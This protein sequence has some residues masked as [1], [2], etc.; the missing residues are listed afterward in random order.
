MRPHIHAGVVTGLATFGM[1][2]IAGTLWRTLAYR[3]KDKNPDSALAE[4]M[5]FVY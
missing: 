3:M 1:V 5:L 2:L 4:A